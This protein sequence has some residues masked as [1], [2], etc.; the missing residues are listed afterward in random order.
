MSFDDLGLA[1]DLE[2]AVNDRGYRTPTPIQKRA[3]PLI[4]DGIDVLAAAQTGTG[5]TAAFVLPMLQRL[6][7]VGFA[8][9][10]QVRSLIIVP[11]RELAAQVHESIEAYGARLDLRSAVVYG[12]VKIGPQIDALSKGVD[13][14]VATPGR[15]L[16]L[17][18]QKAMSL[19]RVE[20]LVLDEA[21]RMLDMGF[22]PDIRRIVSLL[23]PTRQTL[24]FSATFSR[25]IRDLA[26]KFLVDPQTIEVA[27]ANTAAERVDQTVYPVHRTRKTDLLVHLLKKHQWH[28]VLVF[29]RTKHGANRLARRLLREGFECAA[30]HGNKSQNARRRALQQFKDGEI[31]ALLATDIAA[32]GLDID[33]LPEVVNYDLPEVAEDYVHRIGRTGRAGA[34]GRSHSF[35]SEDEVPLLRA[36]EKLLGRRI[37]RDVLQEFSDPAKT[38][39]G[40]HIARDGKAAGANRHSNNSQKG[41][42]AHDGKPARRR[43][44]RRR[45]KTASVET[46]PKKPPTPAAKGGNRR[47]PVG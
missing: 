42:P 38:T 33:Q 31:Q 27:P 44:G 43:R 11:T 3:I 32:R 15:L 37:E 6:A 16:D 8:A 10:R 26:E 17:T 9:S 41:A 20:V 35:M 7:Y 34:A 18:A 36:I 23:P 5:K 19:D 28:Q 25:P 29:T 4:L 47:A 13:V 21:D 39:D 46:A 45:S 40:A 24:M 30:I 12:G 1:P 2:K 14:L 22:L